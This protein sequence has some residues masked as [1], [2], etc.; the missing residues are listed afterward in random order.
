MGLYTKNIQIKLANEGLTDDIMD[1]FRPTI[2]V[3]ELI[4]NRRDCPSKY[5]MRCYLD[6]T[7]RLPMDPFDYYQPPPKDYQSIFR[8]EYR[9][10]NGRRVGATIEVQFKQGQDEGWHQVEYA[11]KDY[12]SGMRY[13]TLECSGSGMGDNSNAIGGLKLADCSVKAM[14]EKNAPE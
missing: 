14:C 10:G 8:D 12:P 13:L 11:F 3:S 5:T 6:A 2:V 9:D 7:N 4:G 1:N